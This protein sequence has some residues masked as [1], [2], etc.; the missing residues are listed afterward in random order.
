MR[1]IQQK[2]AALPRDEKGRLIQYAWPGGYLILYLTSRNDVLCPDCA[3][4]AVDDP[5]TFDVDLP[6]F[7]D[8]YYEGPTIQCDECGA[9]I[10]SAYGDP[11]ESIV[12][13]KH[14][15]VLESPS[16]PGAVNSPNES[17]NNRSRT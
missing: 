6:V 3:Q 2:V 16:L 5:E 11:R 14:K 17:E 1:T 12:A 4:K 10:E 8:I 15:N 13:C 7:V 9:F